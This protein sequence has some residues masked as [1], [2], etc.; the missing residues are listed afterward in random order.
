MHQYVQRA[1]IAACLLSGTLL[2]A[3]QPR[4]V[5][6]DTVLVRKP[7]ISQ[8]FYGTLTGKPVVF[9]INAQDSLNL[10][11]NLMA[12]MVESTPAPELAVEVASDDSNLFVLQAAPGT[13]NVFH[14][15]F[16]WDDYYRGPQR[17]VQ[18]PPGRY[19][20][21]LSGKQQTESY[22]LVVG[23]KERFPPKEI[24]NILAL[25]P[26]MKRDFFGK[27]P[28]FAYCNP[29]SLMIIGSAALL[30]GLIYVIAR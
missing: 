28:W 23:L 25:L 14:E 21:R 12:P 29:F 30:V 17:T 1:V 27:S 11:V 8:A 10:H 22:V 24:L 15:F 20:L 16:I 6:A 18:V 4:I 7:G 19:T 9:L 2:L 3:H 5:A 26:R 13:W